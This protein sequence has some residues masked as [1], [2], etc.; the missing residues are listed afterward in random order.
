MADSLGGT[1]D[2]ARYDA[3]KAY[4][5]GDPE[6]ARAARIRAGADTIW[7]TDEKEIYA[8]LEGLTAAERE[9]V[10][11]KVLTQTKSEDNPNGQSLDSIL[12]DEFSDEQLDKATELAKDGKCSPATE[13][14]NALEGA[15][16]DDAAL[17]KALA[18]KSK[19]EI[20]AIRKDYDAR[21][22]KD[23][24][25][26]GFDGDVLDENLNGRED[27]LLELQLTKG[28]P[29]TDAEKLERIKDLHGIERGDGNFMTRLAPRATPAGDMD[30]QLAKA[31]E[32]ESKLQNGT[33]SDDDKQAL[34]DVTN[35]HANSVTNYRKAQEDVVSTMNTVSD[36]VYATN[37][38]L[39]AT[40]RIFN[41]YMVM[42][43][44][45]GAGEI[46]KDVGVEVVKLGVQ[47][48]T[49]IVGG[50]QFMQGIGGVGKEVLMGAFKGMLD[51]VVEGAFDEA[52][53]RDLGDYVKG[54]LSKGATGAAKGAAEALAQAVI[55][56]GV[57][58]LM[59]KFPTDTEGKARLAGAI[60]ELLKGAGGLAI[61]PDTYNKRWEDTAKSAVPGILKNMVAGQQKGAD[62]Y[63]KSLTKEFADA[64]REKH[65][66]SPDE[67]REKAI[68]DA[69]SRGPAG[70]RAVG[71]GG[72]S[73]RSQCEG[74]CPR[75]GEE[76]SRGGS[77]GR[78]RSRRGGDGAQ[79]GPPQ[80]RTRAQ[81]DRRIYAIPA[82]N[83]RY[84]RSPRRRRRRQRPRLSRP[85]PTSR[86]PEPSPMDGYDSTPTPGNPDPIP[87]STPEREA[88]ADKAEA[89]AL[90][91][92]KSPAK[93]KQL[94]DAE[95]LY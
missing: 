39:A 60:E 34:T 89:D 13:I 50:G 79:G 38:I 44:N 90:A 87:E 76:P 43:D 62:A 32:L 86:Q 94:H 74:A 24:T 11:A 7:G 81:P 26:L 56:G 14:R 17:S 20:E 4:L 35:Y 33:L 70:R 3:V 28:E 88:R 40:Q 55:D 12:E 22:N 61:N 8:Q 71:Q 45:Y 15:G 80:E 41:K 59:S 49:A 93:A 73:G 78:R 5:D 83:R 37:P 27:K 58:K 52:A 25:G 29:Q 92:G 82:M 69:I 68:Q 18:G 2:N 91:Q 75:R 57:G 85:P 23:G 77:R 72:R 65:K 19:E 21:Y 95:L 6:G 54:M 30:R 63:N 51:G 84:L 42:E 48:L 67:V 9:A 10:R 1:E 47:A 46:I 36:A 16:T 64:A 66:N 31:K 53:I